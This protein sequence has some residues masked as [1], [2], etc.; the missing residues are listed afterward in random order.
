MFLTCRQCSGERKPVTDAP[1]KLGRV[2]GGEK[3]GRNEAC[4]FLACTGIVKELCID[5]RDR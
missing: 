1:R 3:G 5:K 4:S 2:D